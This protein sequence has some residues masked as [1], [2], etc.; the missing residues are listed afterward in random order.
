MEWGESR[1]TYDI[2]CN[3][4]FTEEGW[5]SWESNEVLQEYSSVWEYTI[6]NGEDL[7]EGEWLTMSTIKEAVLYSLNWFWYWVNKLNN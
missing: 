3:I 5:W 1:G 2:H 4:K 7:R 6:Y